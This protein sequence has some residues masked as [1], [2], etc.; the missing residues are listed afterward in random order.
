VPTEGPRSRSTGNYSLKKSRKNLKKAHAESRL[1]RSR[2]QRVMWLMEKLGLTYS[3][4]PF[5]RS[6][7]GMAPPELKSIHPMGKL[8]ILSIEAPR[9]Q[10]SSASATAE[11]TQKPPLVLAESAVIMEYL[12]DHFGSPAS[13]LVP[14][15]YTAGE[16][17]AEETEGWLRYRYFMHFI[18]QVALV[19]NC[20]LISLPPP[21]SADFSSPIINLTAGAA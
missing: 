17:L 19:F 14:R 11:S 5:K 9:L 20:E 18:M 16:G 1:E 21:L 10:S 12:L 15:R 2:A 13:S 7:Q 4:K 8:P 6:P 3:I